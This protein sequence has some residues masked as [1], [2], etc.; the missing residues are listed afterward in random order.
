MR[1]LS[2]RAGGPEWVI[3]AGLTLLAF[4][5]HLSQ[6][7]Q[8]LLGDEG[9]T[10]QDIAGRSF[11]SVLTTV[12]T[13]GENSP[14]LFF[15][16]A[17][18]TSKLGDGSVWLRL[19]SILLSAA[20]VPVLFAI[21]R[22]TLGDA[23]GLIA[24]A[25]FAVSPFLLFYGV[26]ARP[27]ATMMFC[28]T[29]STLALLRALASGSP[30]W[31]ALYA[32]AAAGAAYSH[33]T[34]IFV[35]AVQGIWSLWASRA[36]IVAPLA[37]NAAVAV[38]YLP[39][40]PHVRGKALAVIGFLQPLTLHN[41]L[42]DLVRAT[43][44]YPYAYPHQIPTYAGLAAVA[45][46]LGVAAVS[47]ARAQRV[48]AWRSRRPAARHVGLIAALTLATPVGLLLY[49][50]LDT[51]LWLAR[52][53]SASLPAGALLA[54]GLLAAPPRRV[55]VGTTLVVLAILILA[56]A[57]ALQPAYRRGPFRAIAAY[58]DR[59]AG[60]EDPVLY[61]SV[62]GPLVL[63]EMYHHPH[64]VVAGPTLKAH[65][66]AAGHRAYLV[67]DDSLARFV[68]STQPRLPG[69]RFVARTHFDGLFPTS[70]LTYVPIAGTG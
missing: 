4:A 57:T 36:R 59:V 41:I 56:S 26:E 44:G 54:G 34:S 1:T 13:G 45:L 40:L 62:P 63:N 15:I 68:H 60:P 11:W 31:W 28:V 55:A 64:R 32:L 3:V 27:Y 51:D 23:A 22:R 30:G 42:N 35:L 49:S 33:Y 48:S 14:P 46:A 69:L 20:T 66:P 25:L 50:L 10:Y 52:G 29:V 19:P 38:L 7:H 6:I 47:V 70:V 37:A 9:F 24:A 8:S 67:L 18:M 58:L 16:L 53:L 2:A 39:W 17:W 21:G 61:A 5:L 43:V 12:H 65:P